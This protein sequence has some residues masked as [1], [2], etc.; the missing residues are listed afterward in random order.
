MAASSPD[1]SKGASGWRRRWL[2][3]LVTLSTAAAAAFFYVGVWRTSLPP[4][5]SPAVDPR[6]EYQGPFQNVGPSVA[7]VS[8]ARCAECHHDIAISYAQH[9]MGRSLYPAQK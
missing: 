9:A 7:Y 3:T 4:D 2:A 1:R 8:E 6:R 5:D